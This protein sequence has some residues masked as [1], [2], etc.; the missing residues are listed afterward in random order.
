MAALPDGGVLMETAAFL[1]E[2]VRW[3]GI[4]GAIVAAAFLAVG[5]DRI[6]PNARGSYIFRVL[7]IPAVILIW[8]LVLWRWAVLEAGRDQWPLRHAPPRR[9]HAKVWAVMAVVVP[10]LLIAAL[11]F[12]Q[13]WPAD[14]TPQKIGE[15][16][17]AGGNR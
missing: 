8:P 7:L 14:F 3:W 5:V 4:A 16:S 12:K 2:A 1:I 17:H 11:S 15:A 13:E 10:L 9:A 6:E